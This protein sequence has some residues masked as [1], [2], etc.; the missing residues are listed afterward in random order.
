MKYDDERRT[1]I[2]VEAPD[3]PGE[4]ARIGEVLG[5][6]EVN[7]IAAAVLSCDGLSRIHLVV[8]DADAALLAFKREEIPWSQS[9]EVLVVTLEDR[10]GELG[11]FARGL[12][13]RNLN[14]SALYVAGE[15][16]GD[17]ELIVAL[18]KPGT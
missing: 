8:D 7:V 18:E 15:R 16:Q 1:E 12:A 9:R 5:R 6:A 14:I 10:P 4:L 3:R 11:R 13:E 2:I 17:K